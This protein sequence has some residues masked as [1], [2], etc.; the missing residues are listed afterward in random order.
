[1]TEGV[2]NDMAA[3]WS[4]LVMDQK[5]YE[6]DGAVRTTKITTKNVKHESISELKL[7]VN[8]ELRG[9]SSKHVFNIRHQFCAYR[10]LKES[11]QHDE[12]VMHIDFSQNYSCGYYPEVQACH[13]GAS[14]SLSDVAHRCNIHNQWS[15]VIC[16]NLQQFVT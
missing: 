16:Y 11:L 9:S 13:C 6:K 3:V 5:S 2:L 7:K 4:E 14:N 15:C 1:M 10:S 12:A 8:E